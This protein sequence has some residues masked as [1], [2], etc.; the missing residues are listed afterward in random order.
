MQNERGS[1]GLL[2]EVADDAEVQQNPHSGHQVSEFLIVVLS[3][4]N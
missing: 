4:R 1:D 2:E 3:I